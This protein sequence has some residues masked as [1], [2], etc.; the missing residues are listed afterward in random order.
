MDP[1]IAK[2]QIT[3]SFKP[4][5]NINEI[6][7]YKVDLSKSQT[8]QKRI[9]FTTD[10]TSISEKEFIQGNSFLED[11]TKLQWIKTTIYPFLKE[12]YG[13]AKFSDFLRLCNPYEISN[14][15][16]FMDRAGV[17]LGNCDSIF[18]LTQLITGSQIEQARNGRF[19]YCDIAGAPGA[20]TQYVQFRRPESFTYGISLNDPTQPWKTNLFDTQRFQ[21]YYGPD[22]TGDL[23]KH[24]VNF[25][26]YV[27]GNEALGVDMAGADGGFSVEDE[28]YQEIKHTRLILSECIAAILSLKVG[29]TFILKMFSTLTKFSAD[30]IYLLSWCFDTVYLFKPMSSRKGNSEKYFIGLALR[31]SIQDVLNIFIE[32]YNTWKEQPYESY[33]SQILN[34][35]PEDFTKWLTEMNHVFIRSELETAIT[36]YTLEKEGTVNIPEYNLPKALYIWNLPDEYDEKYSTS[37]IRIRESLTNLS[38]VRPA[39]T[40]QTIQTA[41]TI[42]NAEEQ[43]IIRILTSKMQPT[44]KHIYTTELIKSLQTPPTKACLTFSDIPGRLPY[45]QGTQIVK[46]SAHIGQRKL[47]IS[48]LRFL[49]EFASLT[50]ET[51]VVYAGAAPGTHIPYLSYLFPSCKFLLIDPSQFNVLGGI[52]KPDEEVNEAFL[53]RM[54]NNLGKIW[55]LKA[56][57][58][59]QLAEEI[60]KIFPVHLFIS[61]I[62]TNEDKDSEPD[63]KDIIVNM[64]QQLIWAI[65]LK[66][67]MA[68]F[69]FRY[70]FYSEDINTFIQLARSEKYYPIFQK[71]KTLT[72]IDFIQDTI[73]KK[74]HYFD[75]IVHI[76]AWARLTSTESRLITDCKKIVDW[77]IAEN[78][79]NAFF[80]YNSIARCYKTHINENIDRTIGFDLCNDCSI[81]NEAWKQYITRTNS[82]FSLENLARV[83]EPGSVQDFVKTLS[84]TTHNLFVG[85]H[86][87]FYSTNP[88]D[89]L[90]AMRGQNLQNLQN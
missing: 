77:G 23:F 7:S 9:E 22:N 90:K 80:Y 21:A 1:T 34:T 32:V 44:L 45:Q 89:I 84:G 72:N 15:S 64:A 55:L 19:V 8:V 59:D 2:C 88:H 71:A 52:L 76:Q 12:K 48:E 38:S 43:E 60:Q 25:G 24:A 13:K 42:E 6:K 31:H 14:T 30:L 85:L 3:N 28:R 51:I 47:F 73:D 83:A 33:C 20:W 61:D 75:G 10:I 74:L 62:R 16:I 17:K 65:I 26:M 4:E 40:I 70:P 58:T 66:P 78:Y 87:H 86:G 56:L 5:T 29:G 37:K 81:E 79:D 49:T 41:Q 67:Q 82:R 53:L 39:Q 68:M 35:L 18:N 54:K 57:F 27:K 50:T 63:T 69:K 36:V 46:T 11:Y